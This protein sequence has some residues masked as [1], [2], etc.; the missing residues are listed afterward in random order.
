MGKKDKKSKKDKKQSIPKKS[1][2]R[3]NNEELIIRPSSINTFFSCGYQ[4]AAVFLTGISSIPSSRA[5]IGTG[6]HKGAEVMWSQAIKKKR[7]LKK[8]NMSELHD[9]AIQ[10][11]QE[12]IKGGVSYNEGETQNTCEK[13]IIAGVNTYIEDIEP[14]ADLPVAVERRY[15]VEVDNPIVKAISGTVDYITHD[16]IADIKTS[17]RK[18][19]LNSYIAQQSAYRMLAEQ[20]GVKVKRNVIQGVVLTQRPKGMIIPLDT[21]VPQTKASLQIM[22]DTLRLAASDTIPLEQ[23]F[24]PNP[25][26]YLCSNKYCA[27]HGSCPATKKI[28]PTS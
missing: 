8:K 25:N 22:L 21:Q 17:K 14:F 9:A 13:E 6:I 2:L 15:T 1:L 10:E 19:A 16:T 7:K 5:S 27:L 24:R 28:R 12:D 4:W 18:P 26:H 11:F 3:L 20:N 23:L